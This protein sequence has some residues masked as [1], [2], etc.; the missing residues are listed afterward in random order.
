MLSGQGPTLFHRTRSLLEPRIAMQ[1]PPESQAHRPK[2]M[3]I[4]RRIGAISPRTKLRFTGGIHSRLNQKQQ[5]PGPFESLNDAFQPEQ[6]AVDG[7]YPQQA[8]EPGG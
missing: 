7:E 5:T 6:P 4:G 8:P 3:E 1:R 2:K